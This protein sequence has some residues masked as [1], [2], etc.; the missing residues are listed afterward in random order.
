MEETTLTFRKL[1]NKYEL[2]FKRKPLTK[3]TN[4]NIY[5]QIK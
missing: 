5:K 1:N 2:G 4:L 3:A